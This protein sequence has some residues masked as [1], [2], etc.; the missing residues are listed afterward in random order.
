MHRAIHEEARSKPVPCS[1]QWAVIRGDLY[2]FSGQRQCS[3]TPRQR[4]RSLR[5]PGYDYSQAGA[6]FITACIRNRAML[7]GEVIAG[8]VR[9]SEMGT[10]VRQGLG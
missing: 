6:Y 5:L 10:I 7:F 1:L 2:R 3:S 9:L 4:R 8:V